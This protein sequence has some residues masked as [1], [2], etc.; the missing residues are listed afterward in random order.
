MGTFI[1]ICK[2]NRDCSAKEFQ[3]K[4]GKKSRSFHLYWNLKVVHENYE[5]VTNELYGQDLERIS[6]AKQ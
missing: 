5:K 1:L 6:L 2:D 4:E 3:W